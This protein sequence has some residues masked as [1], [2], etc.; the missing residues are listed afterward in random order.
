MYR[1]NEKKLHRTWAEIDDA[2]GDGDEQ[3]DVFVCINVSPVT[4]VIHYGENTTKYRQLT[5]WRFKS[6]LAENIAIERHA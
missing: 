1:E 2:S 6:F 3:S 4:K 5:V